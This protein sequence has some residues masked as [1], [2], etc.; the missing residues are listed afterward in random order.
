MVVALVE[1]AALGVEAKAVGAAA[2]AE[3]SPGTS[4]PSSFF[5]KSSMLEVTSNSNF[6]GFRFGASPTTPTRI[7]PNLPKSLAIHLARK[8]LQDLKLKPVN[9]CSIR[10]SPTES[11]ARDH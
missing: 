9:H 7:P 5:E 10:E 11:V 4:N 2:V 8:E 3:Q 6:V 1:E